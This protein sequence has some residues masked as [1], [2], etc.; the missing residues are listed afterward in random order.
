[1]QAL[2]ARRPTQS[3]RMR[4]EFMLVIIV[5]IALGYPLWNALGSVDF[6]KGAVGIWTLATLAALGTAMTHA[7]FL[8]APA[9]LW[10]FIP[11]AMAAHPLAQLTQRSWAV[12][13][14]AFAV[15]VAAA[16]SGSAYTRWFN[17]TARPRHDQT[18]WP[19]YLD[20]RFN[21]LVLLLIFVVCTALAGVV[22]LI[23]M[24]A[25]IVLPMPQPAAPWLAPL[26]GL[27]IV[28]FACKLVPKGSIHWYVFAL[29]LATAVLAR[30]FREALFGV[31]GDNDWQLIWSSVM[32]PLCAAGTLIG[33]VRAAKRERAGDAQNP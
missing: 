25:L 32:A 16:I 17:A 24:P 13:V 26:L 23:T 3:G 31:H 28:F 10:V 9:S 18:H 27:P 7:L 15:Y 11:L 33:F 21:V 12:A 5:I 1:M 4:V 19:F 22:L 8:Y 20:Q 30:E 29:Y 14:I 2:T 6:H